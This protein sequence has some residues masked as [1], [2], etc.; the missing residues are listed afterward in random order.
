M[1][2]PFSGR[3][4]LPKA[5]RMLSN[6]QQLVGC[7]IDAM[8]CNA[9]LW[10]VVEP[11]PRFVLREDLYVNASANMVAAARTYAS[12]TD[13]IPAKKMKVKRD[14]FVGL[15]V[16]HSLLVYIVRFLANHFKNASCLRS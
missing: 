13:R 2:D 12:P 16:M 7:E 4:S 11:F 6:H 15:P 10:P 14:A 9:P 8:C 3:Y 5:C 1:V